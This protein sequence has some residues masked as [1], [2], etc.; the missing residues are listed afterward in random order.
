MPEHR[1][2]YACKKGRHHR[3]FYFK[4]RFAIFLPLAVSKFRQ[5]EWFCILSICFMRHFPHLLL[6]LSC[7]AQIKNKEV[8][9][10]QSILLYTNTN[11]DIHGPVQ[12]IYA[13]TFRNLRGSRTWHKNIKPKFTKRYKFTKDG[14]F[15]HWLSKWTETQSL[16]L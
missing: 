15:T 5:R 6:Y 9:A 14:S 13:H 11:I 2:G 1:I 4:L 7:I 3:S 8:I 12:N 10:P 16:K